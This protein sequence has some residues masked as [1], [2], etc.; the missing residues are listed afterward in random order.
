[1]SDNLSL[2]SDSQPGIALE[3]KLQQLELAEKERIAQNLAT[4]LGV[5]Y[6]NLST[7][8]ISEGAL[9]LIPEATARELEAVCFLWMGQE[10]RLAAID[11][12]KPEIKQLAAA[13]ERDKHLH[14]KLYTISEHSWQAALKAY[15]RLPKIREFIK[16]V[17]IEA[18]EIE[19]FKAN[20]NDFKE[21]DQAIKQ[22]SISEVVSFLIA[23]A[24]DAKA[25][26]I[27]IEA[28]ENDIKI[29]LRLDGVL[30]T[31]A[32]LDKDLWKQIVSRIKLLAGLKI[33]IT[34]QPQDGR[35]TIFLT[36]DK[37]DV[38]VSCLPTSYGESVVMRL[39]MSEAAGLEFE[40]LGLRGTALARLE[41]EIRRPNGMIITTGP[42][43]SGKTT[44]LYAVI[45][46]LNQPDVKIVTLE[47]PIEYKLPG[48]NQSQ[49][50][51]ESGY[52][53]AKGL[54]AIVRQDPNIVMVGE[55]RDL[56]TAETAINAALT[57]HLVI[58]TLHTNSA[59]AA[60]PRFLSLGVK[61][62]L[63]APALNAV[64]GQR[65]VR[66]LC[67]A[68]RREAQVAPEV[69]DRAREILGQIPPAAG[70][71]VDLDNLKFYIAPGCPQCHGL[72]YAGRIGIYEILIMTPEIEAL[73]LGDKATE[74]GVLKLAQA[75]GMVTMVQD[76]LLKALEGITSLDEV[77]R[78]A[79]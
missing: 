48:I 67:P 14:V 12:N 37:V 42:T 77:F 72:G 62:F 74:D 30:Q 28:E 58:S 44:T 6:V 60:L 55:I 36:D 4:S 23:A 43:G 38:R 15:E 61:P 59:A 70:E 53:F 24:L 51:M 64:M 35:F 8:A 66:R 2:L 65:L 31:V 45:K 78:V 33:N 57:G 7:F 22:V 25:S 1:M 20:V 9:R 13:L 73:V 47:D 5:A 63:L 54:K 17:K 40:K 29:R 34:E 68:C 41:K 56:E 3:N 16:G 26:D 32:S 76:G 10:A 79:E 69:L 27:H 11:P 39:L 75:D 21:L 52:T 46:K 50:D 19:K 18:A 71:K 49:V